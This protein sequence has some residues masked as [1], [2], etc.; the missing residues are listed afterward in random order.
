MLKPIGGVIVSITD[1]I[2]VR[3]NADPDPSLGDIPSDMLRANIHRQREM[4][5]IM[6]DLLDALDRVRAQLNTIQS[7]AHPPMHRSVNVD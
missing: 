6:R 3:G 2:P 7:L 5:E 1:R 4:L